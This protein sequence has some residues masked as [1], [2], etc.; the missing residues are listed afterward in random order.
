MVCLTCD[1]KGSTRLDD[2]L[3]ELGGDGLKLSQK[4]MS[5]E[6]LRFSRDFQR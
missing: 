6:S 5:A 1:S 2:A 4:Q 3:P